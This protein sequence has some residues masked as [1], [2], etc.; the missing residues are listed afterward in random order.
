MG[1]LHVREK[2][3]EED[4]TVTLRKRSICGTKMGFHDCGSRARRTSDLEEFGVGTVLYFQFIKYMGFLFSLMA[5]LSLPTMFFF[6]YGTELEDETFAKI[7]T[8]ASL[9]N[10]GSSNPVCQTGIYNTGAITS[11]PEVTLNLSC[12]FGELFAVYDFGQLSAGDVVNC[13]ETQDESISLDDIEFNF[14]PP[15][16]HFRNKED[17]TAFDAVG[18]IKEEFKTQCK[19][20]NNCEFRF[21][22]SNLP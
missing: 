22:Q 15:T 13:Q 18:G 20:K 5:I 6:F 16:C 1:I 14:Y 17:E 3:H 4:G 8:A 12:P 9:G 11:D 21:R 10:L 7:V 2:V 19:G